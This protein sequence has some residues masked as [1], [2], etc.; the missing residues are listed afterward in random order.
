[1][2]TGVLRSE[3]QD[4]RFGQGEEV[5]GLKNGAAERAVDLEVK[6]GGPDRLKDPRGLL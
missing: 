4:L 3:L 6:A 2:G 1:M 5:L